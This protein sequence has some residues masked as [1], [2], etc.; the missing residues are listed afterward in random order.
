[1]R[2]TKQDALQTR[3]AILDA[4]E[5]L[6]YEKGV[7]STTLGHIA[8][9]AGLTRGAI[10]WHFANKLVLFQAMQDRARLPQEEFFDEQACAGRRSLQDLY[11]NTIEALRHLERDERTRKVLTILLFRCEYVGEMQ[12][13]MIRRTDAEE[14]MHKAVSGIFAAVQHRGELKHEWEPKEAA[15]AYVCAVSGVISEWLRSDRG[16]DLTGVGTR[17]VRS[18]IAGFA[19]AGARVACLEEKAQTGVVADAT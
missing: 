10:Y 5:T 18:V 6:F 12:D 15:T 13:A 4:A 14:T 2:R 1:M 17:V 11:E 7:A 3:E 8:A 19:C 16:F 9:T